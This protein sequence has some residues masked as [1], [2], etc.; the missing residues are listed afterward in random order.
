MDPFPGN[1]LNDSMSP[2]KQEPATPL[3]Q[4]N[5]LEPTSVT[6][7]PGGASPSQENGGAEGHSLHEHISVDPDDDSAIG[8][9]SEMTSMASARASVFEF[10]QEEDGRTYHRFRRGKYMLP[11]DQ[12]EQDRLNLQHQ[13]WLMTLQGQ[14]S[15]APRKREPHHVL[16]IGTGTG[17][18]ALDYALENPTAAVIGSDLSPIRPSFVPVNCSFEV[19]DFEDEWVYEQQFD[20]IHGRLLLSCLANPKQMFEQAFKQLAPG[21]YLEMQDCDFPAVT[22]DDSMSGTNLGKWFSD[23][24]AGAAALGRDLGIVKHYKQWMEEI[25]F[26]NVEEK[27][28]FWPINTWPKDPHLK[29]LGFWYHHDL[30]ELITGLKPPFMRGLGWTLEEIENFQVEVKKDVADRNIH[31]FHIIRVVYGMKPE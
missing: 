3:A 10:V 9:F 15:L 7:V 30:L 17:A 26:L 27:L 19:E 13:L 23:M 24:V 21:G 5:L 8:G 16:D 14:L 22:S 31:A 12:V 20:L 29:K 1:P 18:W 25:G 2:A 4:P 28:F 11:N 6:T